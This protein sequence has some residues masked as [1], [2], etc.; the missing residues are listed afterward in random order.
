MLAERLPRDLT[1]LVTARA[2]K[3]YAS[4]LGWQPVAGVNGTIA[5]FHHPSD[6]LRQLIV[7]LDETFDDY[8]DSIAEAVTKLAEFEGCPATEVLNHLLLPPADVLRF[9]EIG[10]DTET[11]TVRLEQVIGLLEGTK[12]MLL[13]VAH[14][15][16]HPQR[17]HPRLSR[18]EADQFIRSCRMGQTERGSFTVTVACPLDFM[19]AATL[20]G[21]PYSRQITQGLLESLDSIQKATEDNTVD[22]LAD[23][24]KHPLLSA[25]L[26]EGLLMLRPEADRASVQVS[27]T[28]SKA[29]LQP[30][31]QTSANRLLLRKECFEA[32]EYLAPKL[33]SA[34]QPRPVAHVGYV[35]QLRGQELPGG[36]MAGEVVLFIQ[37]GADAIRARV[38][39]T[40]DQYQ[41]A[42]KAHLENLPVFFHGILIRGPRNNRIN[43][44]DGFVLLND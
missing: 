43:Q 7:P 2:I 10:P 29:I 14:S 44:V 23:E 26:L 12:K 40:A 21:G 1:R 33:R 6:D 3:S 8:G 41:I 18:T 4:A 22:D 11:G 42:G 16:L 36:Q 17:Y 20:G 31:T 15:V 39:L 25:N 35:D 9:R 38:D 37:D 13:S 5:V 19:P 32:V 28:W 30:S 24:K 34:P 27:A